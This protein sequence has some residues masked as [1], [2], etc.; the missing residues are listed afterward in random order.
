MEQISRAYHTLSSL[1]KLNKTR[2]NLLSQTVE[3][4]MGGN[5]WFSSKKAKVS[6]F[7]KLPSVLIMYVNI[8]LKQ[9]NVCLTL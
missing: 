1:N 7:N 4:V 6:Q 8:V 2:N 3:K 9:L 5:E